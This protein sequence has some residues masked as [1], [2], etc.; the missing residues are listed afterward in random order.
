MGS[1]RSST[2]ICRARTP[3]R[4]ICDDFPTCVAEDRDRANVNTLVVASIIHTFSADSVLTAH[5]VMHTLVAQENYGSVD[6]QNHFT[7]KHNITVR[8]K[9]VINPQ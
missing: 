6:S 4:V 3:G 7:P 9:M 2:N 1:W 5:F 8:Y